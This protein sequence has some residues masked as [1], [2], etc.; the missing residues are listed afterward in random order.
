MICLNNPTASSE[1]KLLPQVEMLFLKPE[2]SQ[3][4]AAA[5]DSSKFSNSK[6]SI[7]KMLFENRGRTLILAFNSSGACPSDVFT[8]VSAVVDA[9]SA[10]R[11]LMR[12]VTIPLVQN[13]AVTM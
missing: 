9:A 4:A 13:S 3:K 7:S 10:A 2:H 12:A 11:P 1:C 5:L 6:V 8:F